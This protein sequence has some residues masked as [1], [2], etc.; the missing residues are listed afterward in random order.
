MACNKGKN[1]NYKTCVIPEFLR[2]NIVKGS[3]KSAGLTGF[4]NEAGS[5]RHCHHYTEIALIH[6]DMIE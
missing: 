5:P 4:V 1:S 6:I 3:L 2:K